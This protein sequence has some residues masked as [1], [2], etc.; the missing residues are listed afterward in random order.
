MSY[1]TRIEGKRT[2]KKIFIVNFDSIELQIREL[3]DTG[4]EVFVADFMI[5][6]EFVEYLLKRELDKSIDWVELCQLSL[7]CGGSIVDKIAE[8]L[9]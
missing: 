1:L 9:F 3:N 7:D 2:G 6:D 5:L 4:D 8:H